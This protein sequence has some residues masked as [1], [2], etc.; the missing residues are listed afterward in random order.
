MI[1]FED[2]RE[3]CPA[4][5]L[6]RYNFYRE[7]CIDSGRNVKVGSDMMPMSATR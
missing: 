2:T 3:K 7:Y 1:L 6:D 4:A 5:M